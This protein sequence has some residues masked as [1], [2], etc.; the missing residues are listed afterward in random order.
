MFST[1]NHFQMFK[2]GSVNG[3]CDVVKRSWL[4]MTEKDIVHVKTYK[5]TKLFNIYSRKYSDVIPFVIINI[6]ISNCNLITQTQ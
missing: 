5:A 4:E 3:R 6:F 1:V 2:P